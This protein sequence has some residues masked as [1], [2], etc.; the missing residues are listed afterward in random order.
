MGHAAARL[1][2]RRRA[3]RYGVEAP[4]RLWGDAPDA[5]EGITVNVSP[6]GML[7]RTSAL[8]APAIASR[9]RFRL[10]LP[11]LQ[12]PSGASVVGVGRV[13]RALRDAERDELLIATTIDES[14]FEPV[15]RADA[16]SLTSQLAEG[17]G[18]VRVLA[19]TPPDADA[20]GVTT[21]RE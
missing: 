19:D 8:Q 9:V 15:L 20:A 7:L 1:G 14:A 17:A 21:A 6:I 11:G 16:R 10:G 2:T 13:V 18:L 3:Q 4:V 12:T 5:I